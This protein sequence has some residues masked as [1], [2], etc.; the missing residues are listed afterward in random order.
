MPVFRGLFF[1]CFEVGTAG[2]EEEDESDAEGHAAVED[3]GVD[4]GRV[5]HQRGEEY[6]EE[7]TQGAGEQPEAGDDALEVL[8]CSGVGVFQTGGAYEDFGEGE[9]EV[10]DAL[11]EDA[12]LGPGV[13]FLLQGCHGSIGDAGQQYAHAHAF[14]RCAPASDVWVYEECDQGDENHDEQGI[15]ALHFLCSEAEFDVAPAQVDALHL[16]AL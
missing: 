13:E 10:G 1:F 2:D 5:V 4:S 16:L 6:D 11:P 3:E 7:V 12:E 9:Q 8:A 14:E 15:E